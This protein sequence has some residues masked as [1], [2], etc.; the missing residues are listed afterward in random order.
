MMANVAD[1]EKLV[2]LT[3]REQTSAAP[4]GRNAVGTTAAQ[5]ETMTSVYQARPAVPHS[6]LVQTTIV[7]R[8]ETRV[9]MS[10]AA[11]MVKI[12]ALR[13]KNAVMAAVSKKTV[14]KYAVLMAISFVVIDAFQMMMFAATTASTFVPMVTSVF[15]VTAAPM[16]IN[17]AMDSA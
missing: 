11:R 8:R 9:S 16:G 15:K 13:Y 2:V 4:K 14:M 7:V 10:I 12:S 17:Y 3:W 5:E 1:R 6:K